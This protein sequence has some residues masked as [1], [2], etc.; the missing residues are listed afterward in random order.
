MSLFDTLQVKQIKIRTD[1]QRSAVFPIGF[2]LF[3]ESA[4]TFLRIFEAVKLVEENV[5]GVLETIA[6]REAHAAEN[7]FLGHGKHRAGVSV[8]AVYEVGDGFFELWFGDKTIDHAKIESA[9]GGDGFAGQ[10]K[11]EGDFWTDEKRKNRGR[12]RRKDADADF[13]L[14]ETRFGRGDDEVT[15]SRELR[16]AADG[17]TIDNANDGLAEFEH[18][19]KSGMKSVEH[20]EDTLRSVFADV[21]ATAKDFASGVEDDQFDVVTLAGIADAIRHFAE[22]GFVEKIVLGAA[23]GHAGDAAVATELDEFEFVGRALYGR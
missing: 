17:R 3:D 11:F 14:G 22:H 13:R 9:L 16:A 12:K 7:G 8:D 2:A 21:D 10:H 4:Q 1:T 6:Q 19:G 18:A 23:H 15:E 20:L 5:H